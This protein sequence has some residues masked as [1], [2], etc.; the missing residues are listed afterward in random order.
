MS[1]SGSVAACAAASDISSSGSTPAGTAGVVLFIG[2][3]T[4]SSIGRSTPHVQPFVEKN[5]RGARIQRGL[6]PGLMS[7]GSGETLV[8]ELDRQARDVA[9]AVSEV[10][11]LPG[12]R[13]VAAA[14]RPWQAD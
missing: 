5:G 2:D 11:R 9:Q 7:Q 13:G 10:T 4:A 12:L 3:S 1:S 6:P 8:V 14:K